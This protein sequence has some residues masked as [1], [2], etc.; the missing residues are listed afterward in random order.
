MDQ[1][2][3]TSVLLTSIGYLVMEG[4]DLPKRQADL[5]L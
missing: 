2:N 4:G 1:K 3:Y 5:H